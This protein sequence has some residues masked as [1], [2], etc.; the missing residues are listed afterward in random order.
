MLCFHRNKILGTVTADFYAV[1]YYLLLIVA[2]LVA[3]FLGLM[4]SDSHLFITKT[5]SIF[6]I[7]A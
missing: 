5:I 3:F 4:F 2:F 7:L 1:L 6:R